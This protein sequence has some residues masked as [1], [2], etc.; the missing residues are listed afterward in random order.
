MIECYY[1]WCKHHSIN[2]Q[3]DEGPFCDRTDKCV[4]T[5]TELKHFA[6]LRKEEMMVWQRRKENDGN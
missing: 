2:W 3:P 4:A 1:H 5:E 6:I